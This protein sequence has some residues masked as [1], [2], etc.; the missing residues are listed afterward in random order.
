QTV[1]FRSSQDKLFFGIPNE[2]MDCRSH[3]ICF[4]GN[5]ENCSSLKEA[6]SLRITVPASA[7]RWFNKDALE[8]ANAKQAALSQLENLATGIFPA[9]KGHFIGNELFTPCTIKRFTGHINGA[10]YG[11]PDKIRS[12]NTLMKNLHICGTDQGLLGIVGSLTSGI[13][14]ANSCMVKKP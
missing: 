6:S 12:G 1:I 4:P 7:E 2:D 13:I 8:Y 14:T 9:L 5:F 11:S 3:I 10:V